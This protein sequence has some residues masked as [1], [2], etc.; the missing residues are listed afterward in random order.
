M[1]SSENHPS[2][3]AIPSLLEDMQAEFGTCWLDPA[4][5][6]KISQHQIEAIEI[7][8]EHA[9]QSLPAA[10]RAN[11]AAEGIEKMNAA[12]NRSYR[13]I[14]TAQFPT[15]IALISR[16]IIA[17]REKCELGEIPPSSGFGRWQAFLQLVTGINKKE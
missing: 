17:F 13:G 9:S 14:T 15:A 4:H 3:P 11:F 7:A 5:E 10:Y 16:H 6:N 8:L 12:F 2:P 1:S